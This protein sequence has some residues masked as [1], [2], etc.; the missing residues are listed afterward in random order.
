MTKVVDIMQL[1]WTIMDHDS[2]TD[3]CWV[4]R[5]E[6][7]RNGLWIRNCTPYTESNKEVFSSRLNCS[8]PMFGSFGPAAVKH[9]SPKLLY[10]SATQRCVFRYFEVN[11]D[12]TRSDG[13]T[14]NI[15]QRIFTEHRR[16]WASINH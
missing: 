2:T 8:E 3:N 11:N 7:S 10:R 6:T 14:G 13:Q 4:G 15:Y 1:N 9:R 12:A 5:M 16:A